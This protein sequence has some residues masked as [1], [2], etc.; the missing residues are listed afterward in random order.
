[1]V[2]FLAILYIFAL[3]FA[4]FA[5]WDKL[6]VLVYHHI[7]EKVS[8]DVACTPE[9]FDAQMAA[10]LKAGYT[11]ISL[12]QVRQYLI[13][14]LEDI[15]KPILITFDDGY[16]SVFQY[17][18]P[19]AKKYKIPMIVFVVTS[20]IGLKPQFSRYMNEKQMRE[21]AH[22]G[23]FEFGS[24]THSLHTDSMK[25]FDAFGEKKNNPVCRL[26]KRD[27]R[28]SNEKIASILGKKPIAIA[29]PYGKFGPE[30]TSIARTAGF[31]LH[32]TSRYGYN[33]EGFNPYLIKRIPVSSRDTET[34]IIAKLRGYK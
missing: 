6:A 8:S 18:L 12:G 22:S 15:G 13:A 2:V 11:P 25:I 10:L 4:S 16:E 14:G 26:L 34:S 17:A 29:W 23:F 21:M 28:L 20:R 3:P 27:L 1:M 9:Q 30:F 31:K 7:Q 24:H 5:K 19:V 33:E 32:F